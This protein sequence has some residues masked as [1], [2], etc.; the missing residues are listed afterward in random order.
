M[1]VKTSHAPW[2]ETASKAV[3]QKWET[4]L[5][6]SFLLGSHDFL[7]FYYQPAAFVILDVCTNLSSH[8]RVTVTV[9]VVILKLKCTGWLSPQQTHRNI[10]R[11]VRKSGLSSPWWCETVITCIWKNSPISSKM[12]LALLCS[13]SLL[14]PACR[15]KVRQVW[16]LTN[17]VTFQA[18]TAPAQLCSSLPSFT[19][20]HS[21]QYKRTHHVHRRRH[22]EV[23]R[24]KGSLVFHYS[25]IPKRRKRTS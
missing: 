7:G 14:I 21:L 16:D 22:R 17:A 1:N 12:C 4:H 10:S 20:V 25:F 24:V 8:S 3:Q 11:D 18:H 2:I 19:I 9:Q 13:S 23:E 15:G 5:Q 6:F